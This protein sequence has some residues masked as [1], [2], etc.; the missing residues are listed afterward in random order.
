M[1]TRLLSIADGVIELKIVVSSRKLLRIMKI[2]KM[3]GREVIGESI[4]AF[5][6]EPYRGIKILPLSYA[7]A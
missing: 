3:C 5:E 6:V 1:F 2:L 7:K 4:A